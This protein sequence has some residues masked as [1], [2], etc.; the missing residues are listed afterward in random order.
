MRVTR[1]AAASLVSIVAISVLYGTAFNMPMFTRKYNLECGS[2]HTVVPKLTKMGMEFR[3]AGFRMPDDIGKDDTEA[4]NVST[5]MATRLQT[6]YDLARTDNAG[7][8]TDKSQLTFQE[9]TF[10]P[11]TGAFNRNYASLFELSVAPEEPVEIENAYVRGDWKSGAGYFSG[12]VG[13]FHPFEGF[14][15]SDRP[16]SLSRPLFQTTPAK[17]NQSTFFTPWNFDESGLELGWSQENTMLRATLFN[18][19]AFDPNENAAHPAQTFSGAFAKDPS[20]S[21]FHNTDFQILATQILNANGGGL[22][23]YYYN[24]AVALPIGGVADTSAY[25]EDKFDRIAGYGS[26]PVIPRLIV[27]GGVQSGTDKT[28][29]L[30]AS[31]F[32]P[33]STSM[34]Y[35]GEAD[36]DLSQNWWLATR[37]DWFDPSDKKDD[38]EIM[39]GTVAIN[40]PFNNGL[41][42][43]SEYR[44]VATKQG[45]KADKK[46]NAFQTRLIWIW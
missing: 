43:I 17:F 44:Y 7:V 18:G 9:V 28:W 39:A 2:C 21:D 3:A 23:L 1:L 11:L 19:I 31:N 40:K 42:F 10:Y 22:S 24:G 16:V 37:Y 20:R 46:V 5:Q 27:L 34:G 12:R 29:D 41:Q 25:F 33:K 35:F 13:I 26:Y 8:K 38:D 36:V 14:G 30:A 6:R 15:A 4:N 32:G 45:S